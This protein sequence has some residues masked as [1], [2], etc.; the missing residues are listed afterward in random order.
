MIR[1]YTGASHKAIRPMHDLR[2]CRDEI[3]GNNTGISLLLSISAYVLLS[4]PIEP[5]ET[6]STT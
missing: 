4:P 2:T 6:S 1:L 3:T 5:R